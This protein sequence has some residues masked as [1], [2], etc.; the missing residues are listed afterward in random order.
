MAYLSR[1]SSAGIRSGRN[2]ASINVSANTGTGAKTFTPSFPFAKVDE[3]DQREYIVKSEHGAEATGR[4]MLIQTF[5]GSGGKGVASSMEKGQF[6]GLCNIGATSL[7]IFFNVQNYAVVAAGA[8]QADSSGGGTML[9]EPYIS[10]LLE[11]GK[12]LSLPNIRMLI[13]NTEESADNPHSAAV[14]TIV[15]TGASGPTDGTG[16]YTTDNWG[17]N[18]ATGV[19]PAPGTLGVFALAALFPVK[20]R[21]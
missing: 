17:G 3:I 10:M 21:K 12:F 16:F 1:G 9:S 18:T 11:P 19:F 7:E 5:S 14:G 6:L 2:S 8:H 20:R 4:P 15:T 13:F